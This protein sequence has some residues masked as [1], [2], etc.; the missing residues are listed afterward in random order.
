[1]DSPSNKSSLN[2]RGVSTSLIAR[3]NALY[4]SNA[5]PLQSPELRDPGRLR[6][7]G[8]ATTGAPHFADRRQY[9]LD[10]KVREWRDDGSLSVWCFFGNPSG[11][12]D[13]WIHNEGFVG[14]TSILGASKKADQGAHSVIPLTPALEARARAGAVPSLAETDVKPYLQDELRWRVVK[15]GKDLTY[16]GDDQAPGL[17]VRVTWQVIEPAASAEEFPKAAGQVEDLLC[18]DETKRGHF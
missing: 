13:S 12:V 16:F 5:V 10:I 11:P 9:T 3:V 14:T 4:G 15:Q 6:T 17:E 2:A 8:I 7:R 1:M 18:A